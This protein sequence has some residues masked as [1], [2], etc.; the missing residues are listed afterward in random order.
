MGTEKQTR[1]LADEEADA[2]LW[3]KCVAEHGPAIQREFPMM[4]IPV[5]KLLEMDELR[6]HEAVKEHLVE[7]KPGMGSVFFVSH[8]WL[9]W[10]APDKDGVKITLLKSLLR[11]IVDG[12]IKDIKSHYMADAYF[13]G[14]LLKGSSLTTAL[15][16]GYVWMDIM[17][18]P[19]ANPVAQGQAI[20]SIVSYVSDSAY[21]CVL[22]GAWR[23]ENGSVRDVRGWHDRGWC[24]MEMLANALSPKQK[25]LIVAQTPSVIELHAPSGPTERSFALYPVGRGAF[26]VDSDR[27]KLAPVVAALISARKAYALAQGDL[28]WYRV[29]HSGARKLLEGMGAEE[30]GLVPPVERLEE[31]LAS[32]RFEGADSAAACTAPVHDGMTPLRYAGAVAGSV[33]LVRAIVAAA[34]SVDVEAP[35]PKP[36]VAF[37]GPEH[38]TILMHACKMHDS[39][40]LITALLDAGASAEVPDHGVGCNALSHA[41]ISGHCHVIDTLIAHGRAREASNPGA[42]ERVMTVLPSKYDGC[43]FTENYM[44]NFTALAEYGQLSAFKHCLARHPEEMERCFRQTA[45]GAKGCMSFGATMTNWALVMIGNVE[46]VKLIIETSKGYGLD[47]VNCATSTSD[48]IWKAG[49]EQ[50]RGGWPHIPPEAKN[51]FL[52]MLYYAFT[53]TTPLHQASYVANLG[54]LELLLECGAALDSQRHWKQ[55]TPLMMCCVGG[56]LTIATAL[57]DHGASLDLTDV[58]GKR[59]EDVATEYSHTELAAQLKAWR[60]G[61]R[62]RKRSRGSEGGTA[63]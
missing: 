26:T 20:N 39:P 23:H 38:F 59:A 55:M 7:W 2:A 41:C 10:K 21:F 44:H 29:L 62:G 42:Y 58:D 32:M 33:E 35:L 63:K 40:E 27:E 31:W 51:S 15:A 57:L 11:S 34:P 8:T 9:K 53:E 1:E 50:L 47:G 45:E 56:H 37:E 19:Q 16:S 61:D 46:V 5:A 48:P 43:K 28:F 17:S 14:Q 36:I 12:T 22:A 30:Q 3:A 6:P 25:P 13:G 49:L 4:V 52:H 60:E 54:A 18:I 24:R